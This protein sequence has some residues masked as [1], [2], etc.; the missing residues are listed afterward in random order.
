MDLKRIFN[1]PSMQ[2]IHKAFTVPVCRRIV[3]AIVC[4]GRFSLAKVK[5]SQDLMPGMRWK[6]R[7]M[8]LLNLIMDKVIFADQIIHP[9]FPAECE[10]V[11]DSPLT[12][13][14]YNEQ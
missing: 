14:G 1:N 2:S 9:M 13:S 12:N 3:W 10:T 4:D 6:D 7:P 5:M 11:M 8:S